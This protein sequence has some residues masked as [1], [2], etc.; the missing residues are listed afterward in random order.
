MAGFGVYS[1]KE[2]TAV[3]NGIPLLGF[4]EGTGIAWARNEDSSSLQV[5]ST[6]DATLAKSNNRSGRVT[7][8]LIQSAQ[9]N[10]LLSA[11]MIAFEK[12]G[13]G[14]GIGPLLVKD[15]SGTTVL[16]AETSWLLRPAD[17]EL[18]REASEREWVVETNELDVF[19]GGNS[20]P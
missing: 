14:D 15:L 4:A 12:G 5:G 8:T 20:A 11:Q 3:W 13:P 1:I 7:F 9:T 19:V 17:G 16:A 2:V 6:G 18:G 10:D